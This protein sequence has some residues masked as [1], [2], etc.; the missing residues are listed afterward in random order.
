MYRN[1]EG[2]IHTYVIESQDYVINVIFVMIGI[3]AHIDLSGTLFP[4]GFIAPP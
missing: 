4:Y 3:D 1:L 2:S